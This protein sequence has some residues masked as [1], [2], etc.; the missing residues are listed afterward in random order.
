MP[1]YKYTHGCGYLALVERTMEQN[2]MGSCPGCG[3]SV[4]LRPVIDRSTLPNIM[5]SAVTN[6][7]YNNGMGAYD[8]GLGVNLENRQQHERV[9]KEKGVELADKMSSEE[10]VEKS[11]HAAEAEPSI[12]IEHIKDRYEYYKSEVDKG[13]TRDDKKVSFSDGVIPVK[14]GGDE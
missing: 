11:N 5:R 6:H 9:M 10:Y 2:I 14:T 8:I 3:A 7:I 12:P 1:R 4:E 13:R